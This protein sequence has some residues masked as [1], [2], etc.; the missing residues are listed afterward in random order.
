M[1][2][3]EEMNKLIDAYESLLT[4]HQRNVIKMY[5]ADDFSLQEISEETSSS[6]SAVLDL[7]RRTEKI[8]RD[9]ESKLHLVEKEDKK[10]VMITTAC[11]KISTVEKIK[12][13]LLDDKLAAVIQVVNMKSNYRWKGEVYD[14]AEY[15][16]LIKSK[17]SKFESIKEV[18]SSIHDYECFEISVYDIED[19][20]EDWLLWV[21]EEVGE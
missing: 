18:I 5:Y 10:Y 14:E 11:D 2:N 9:Y 19:A 1:K 16:L 13:Q 20:N 3:I 7:I 17:K 12:K 21:D 4:E 15:L 8:L 6:R